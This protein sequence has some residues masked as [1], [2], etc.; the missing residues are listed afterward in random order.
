[1][2]KLQQSLDGFLD[3]CF[4]SHLISEPVRSDRLITCPNAHSA[5]GPDAICQIL[6]DLFKRPRDKA[7]ESVKIGSCLGR[8]C[9]NRDDLN[10]PNVRR[11]VAGIIACAQDRDETWTILVKEVFGVPDGVCRDYVVLGDSVLVAILIQITRKKALRAD[12]SECGVL[13]SLSQFDIRNTATELQHDIF[14]SWNEIV[15]AARN[16]GA[17]SNPTHVLADITSLFC[18]FTSRD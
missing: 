7:L 18:R 2:A 12:G 8:W 3:R 10:D 11:I 14:T 15:K 1:L 16:E 5:L 13:K 17:S 4:S 6:G 9:N